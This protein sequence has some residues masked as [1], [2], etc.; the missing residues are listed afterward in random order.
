MLHSYYQE[1]IRKQLRA[2]QPLDFLIFTEEE[3]SAVACFDSASSNDCR[4]LNEIVFMKDIVD[5]QF[6]HMQNMGNVM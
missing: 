4:Q 2:V 1:E 5:N 3:S 6:A